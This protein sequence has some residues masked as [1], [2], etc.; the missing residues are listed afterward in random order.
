MTEKTTP[1]FSRAIPLETGFKLDRIREAGFYVIAT[2]SDGPTEG[3][4][5]L[6]VVQGLIGSNF[7]AKQVLTNVDT[8]A[9]WVRTYIKYQG[10]SS[11]SE[12][13]TSVATGTDLTIGT[14]DGTIF[15][16]E[17]STGTDVVIPSATTSQAGLMSAADKTALDSFAGGG[18][19]NL[20]IAN[21]TSTTFDVASSTGT[22]ATLP[23][24]T[25]T[26]AGLMTAAMKVKL[27]GIEAGADSNVATDLAIANK[28][29]TT[30]DITSSTG[31]DIT[32][33]QATDTEAG[34]F[35]AANNVKLGY[36]T[37]TG[38]IS[39]DAL[40]GI[41]GLAD[42]NADRLLFWDDSAGGY[43]FLTL[44]TNLS[45]TGTTL[46]AAGGS[47]GGTLPQEDEDTA[48]SAAA[49]GNVDLVGVPKGTLTFV[50]T[51]NYSNK[52]EMFAPHLGSGNEQIMFPRN[53]STTVDH[54]GGSATASGS[55]QSRSVTSGSG[56]L[57]AT[58]RVGYNTSGSANANAGLRWASSWMWRGNAVD[59][60]GFTAC[61]VCGFTVNS[62][63][64]VFIG[65]ANTGVGIFGASDNTDPSAATNTFG[66]GKDA[67]DTNLYVIHNDSTGTA[68]KVDLGANFP[69]D[70]G[71]VYEVWFHAHPNGSDITYAIRRLDTFFRA[72]GTISTNLP[73][74]TTAL[75]LHAFINSGGNSTVYGIDICSMWGKA[76][77][78]MDNP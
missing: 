46:D 45:I 27:D 60:G 13:G 66:I 24:V 71:A 16:I 64:R 30:F 48:P 51:I 41:A 42:P 7:T 61:V 23:A 28:T 68:T 9:E 8:G 73:S 78:P 49:A 77:L 34:L 29:S 62:T 11:W 36:L 52:F 37:V 53:N 70:S 35:T 47:F 43:A 6:E 76:P 74:S 67:A 75:G 55:A 44:G 22:D 59:V 14:H 57:G 4:Y 19:T 20:S 54:F 1:Y 33:P 38:A 17:S 32:L 26:E 21:K 5:V 65:L 31:T 12:R 58:K 39:L 72:E 50:G 2:P 56:I 10:W 3:N 63:Q 69:A 40:A 25:D 18:A 15:E